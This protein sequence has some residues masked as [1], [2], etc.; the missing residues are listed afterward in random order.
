M[1]FH[2]A[3]AVPWTGRYDSREH[4]DEGDSQPG[5]GRKRIPRHIVSSG[6]EGQNPQRKQSRVRQ[7]DRD[8]KNRLSDLQ[9]SQRQDYDGRRPRLT[10]WAPLVDLES[11]RR[12]R[13]KVGWYV[14]D[15]RV[16]QR[17][18]FVLL[19]HVDGHQI[20]Q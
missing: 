12:L 9:A 18:R 6:A 2:G 8:G 16:Q 17:N 19:T 20:A 11:A 7:G 3:V 13:L 5:P 4:P 15:V 14:V 10:K 1:L